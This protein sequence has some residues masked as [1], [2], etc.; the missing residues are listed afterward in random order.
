M[1]KRILPI[2]ALFSFLAGSFGAYAMGPT[3]TPT[4]TE[5]GSARP[6]V[7]GGP[8]SVVLGDPEEPVGRGALS[9]E[10]LGALVFFLD[11]ACRLEAICGVAAGHL[12]QDRD[13]EMFERDLY[14][15]LYKARLKEAACCIAKHLPQKKD[16]ETLE[17]DIHRE[18]Y[19]KTLEFDGIHK[20]SAKKIALLHFPEKAPEEPGVVAKIWE[21]LQD[22]FL[23]C[24]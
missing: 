10:K 17:R 22:T 7:P 21:W 11:V 18:L 24:G 23:R 6:T 13:P 8:G 12:P 14:R 5:L 20:K 3:D 19:A 2:I 16:P 1:K 4:A 9:P 15:K